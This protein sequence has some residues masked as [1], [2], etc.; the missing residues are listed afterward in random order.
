M[1]EG[2]PDDSVGTNFRCVLAYLRRNRAPGRDGESRHSG[3]AIVW[4][5]GEVCP[6]G[7]ELRGGQGARRA[8]PAR[9]PR[10]LP[11]QLTRKPQAHCLRLSSAW[12]LQRNVMGAERQNVPGGPSNGE[13]PAAPV[14]HG[15]CS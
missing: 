1:S 4:I 10:R 5:P 8:G 15:A 14:A 2:R 7:P 6:C 3:S 13:R 11:R 9:P 12:L